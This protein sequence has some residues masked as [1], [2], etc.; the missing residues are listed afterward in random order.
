MGAVQTAGGGGSENERT[1]EKKK[2]EGT[3]DE[4]KTIKGGRGGGE[5]DAD[6][7]DGRG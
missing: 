1:L 4:R 3:R 2:D 7:E 6:V 5:A